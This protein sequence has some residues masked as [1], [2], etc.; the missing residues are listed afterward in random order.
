ML[1][2]LSS[3]VE[4]V[5]HLE[6]NLSAVGLPAQ[7]NRGECPQVRYDRQPE[8]AVVSSSQEDEDSV[9]PW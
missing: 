2:L 5:G 7:A 6:R 3:I 9:R 8:T 4:L 1:K